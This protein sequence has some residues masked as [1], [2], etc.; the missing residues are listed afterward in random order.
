MIPG[1]NRCWTST[2]ICIA[3]A[4]FSRK[5]AAVEVEKMSLSPSRVI[6]LLFAISSG[7]APA[8]PGRQMKLNRVEL[9]FNS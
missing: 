8:P 9:L 6:S 5:W 7:G 1:K 4:G 2:R 3:R